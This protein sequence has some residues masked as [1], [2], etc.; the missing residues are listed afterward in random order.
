MP[1]HGDEVGWEG[2]EEMSAHHEIVPLS[3]SDSSISWG[4]VKFT[5]EISE[6]AKSMEG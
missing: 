4:G 3:K 1:G 6:G 2:G 5:S